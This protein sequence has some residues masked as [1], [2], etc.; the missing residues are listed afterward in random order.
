MVSHIIL[1]KRSY[2]L[3]SSHIEQKLPAKISEFHV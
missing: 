1:H 3:I 2:L